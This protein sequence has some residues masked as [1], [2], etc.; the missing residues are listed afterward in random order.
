MKCSCKDWDD[1]IKSVNAP[2]VFM[3]ARNPGAG[4]YKG[5]QFV[6]CPWCGC[7]LQDDK[8]KSPAN[9]YE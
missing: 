9:D 1:G 8:P 7:H 4:D 6:W 5:K 3:S 2:F